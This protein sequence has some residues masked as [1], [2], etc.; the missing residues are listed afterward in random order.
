MSPPVPTAP[1]VG[2]DTVDAALASSTP[3]AAG[4]NSSGSAGGDGSKPA[5]FVGAGSASRSVL[6]SSQQPLL[7]R[8]E[9]VLLADTLRASVDPGVA[10]A[11]RVVYLDE[12]ESELRGENRRPGGWCVR[13]IVERIPPRYLVGQTQ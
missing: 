1:T 10:R 6:P 2:E 3:S 7:E 12:L 13:F 4:D 5:V 11:M 9:D 8:W